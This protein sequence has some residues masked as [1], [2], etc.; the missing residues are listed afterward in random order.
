[1]SHDPTFWLLARAGGL[2]AYVLLTASVLAGLVLKS[3]P[4]GTALRAATV[5][6][7]HRSLALT[8]LGL[9]ALHGVALVLDRTVEVTPLGLVVPGLVQYR[10]LPTALGV[11]A[12]ELMV[13]VYASFGA[14]KRIGVRAWRRLHYATYGVFAAATA[15]GLFAGSDSS[16]PWALG[17]YVGAIAAVALAGIWR[18]LVV[19][20]APA[21]RG[22]TP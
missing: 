18:A 8:G 17:L 19:A 20:P 4:F 5:T 11:L 10:P 7:V 16:Q 3:R 14:R 13:L 6:A 21:P 15:H 1:M 22:G 2:G 9:L 12:G